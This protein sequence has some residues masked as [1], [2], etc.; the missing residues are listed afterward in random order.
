MAVA[1]DTDQSRN[2]H[3]KTKWRK[4]KFERMQKE[5][6]KYIAHKGTKSIIEPQRTER[7]LDN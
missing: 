4:K 1:T 3:V 5:G 6:E 2:I 7:K